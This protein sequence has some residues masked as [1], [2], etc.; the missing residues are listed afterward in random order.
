MERALEV[1]NGIIA[2]PDSE[3]N[4]DNTALALDRVT[5]FSELSIMTSVVEV[6]EVIEYV[7]PDQAM[8]DAA[9]KAHIAMREFIVDMISNNHDLYKSLKTDVVSRNKE[10]LRPD[11]EYF[12]HETMA[13]FKRAGLDLAPEKLEKAKA[14]L[15][16]L[17]ALG[18]Q[19]E[20]VT[21][22][23]EQVII[24]NKI[25]KLDNC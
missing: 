19:F 24:I 9:H 15:K 25:V 23:G 16:A 7:H 12:L 20:V 22:C 10:Q 4:F 11:Q 21:N 8:R 17:A 3:K 6:V 5:A 14:I 13:D 1:I 2:L 18:M